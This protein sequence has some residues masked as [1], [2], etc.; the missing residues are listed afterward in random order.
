MITGKAKE[1]CRV[2]GELYLK[3]HPMVVSDEF[4]HLVEVEKEEVVVPKETK[5]V[6]AKKK[7]KAKSVKK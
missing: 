5:K 2:K 4:A 6:Y 1:D 7:V 3:G